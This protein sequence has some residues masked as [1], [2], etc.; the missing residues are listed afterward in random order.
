MLAVDEFAKQSVQF[1]VEHGLQTSQYEISSR[2]RVDEESEMTRYEELRERIALDPG[3]Y[4]H[5]SYQAMR[6]GVRQRIDVGSDGL[7]GRS[8]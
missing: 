4:G 5:Q 3:I 7:I 1:A 6:V 2:S 8:V